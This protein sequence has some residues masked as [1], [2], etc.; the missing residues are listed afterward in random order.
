MDDERDITSL[1]RLEYSYG[2]AG[3]QWTV[4]PAV[5]VPNGGYGY[6]TIRAFPWF[7]Q[8]CT[9]ENNVQRQYLV[10]NALG[11]EVSAK[12]KQSLPFTSD[13]MVP[14]NT[15]I[16]LN[17]NSS[18]GTGTDTGTDPEDVTLRKYWTLVGV[19]MGSPPFAVNNA[20]D[21]EIAPLS[22]V[23]YGQSETAEVSN[24]QETANT[25]M[26]SA[27][28]TVQAGLQHVF[29]VKDQVDASYKHAWESANETSTKSTVSYGFTLGTENA[30]TDPNDADQIG[31]MGWAIFHVPTFVV[32]D[33]ALY[34]YDYDVGTMSGTPTGQD[35]HTTQVNQG[36]LSYRQVAFELAS[37][38]G[39][40]DSFPGLMSG[41]APLTTSTDF[42]GW[43]QGWESNSATSATSHYTT[44]LGDSTAGETKINTITFVNG[45]NGQASFS[46]DIET[47]TTTGQTSDVDVSNQ[48]SLDLGTEVNGFKADLKAGYDGHF[49][50]SVTNTTTLGSDVEA[51]LG[52]PACYEPACIKTLTVQPYLLQATDNNAPWIPAGYN[53]QLPWAMHWK[54]MSYTTIGGVQSGVSPP[55]SQ[56]SGIIVGTSEGP[57]KASRSR[58]SSYSLRGGKM[59]WQEDDG[60]LK[61]IPMKARE[62][63]PAL[64]VSLELNGYT[65]S[66][67]EADGKWSRRGS[68]WTFKTNRRVNKDIVVLKLNFATM[69]WDLDLSKADLSPFLKVSEG[70]IHVELSVNG[71]YELYFDCE[72]QVEGQWD[73]TPLERASSDGLGL[74]LSRYKGFFDPFTGMGI[75]TLEGDLPTGLQHFGDISFLVNG[76]QVDVPLISRENYAKALA[77][78]KKL[79]VR[80]KRGLQ[81]FLDFGKNKWQVYFHGKIH[82]L[83]MPRLA[84]TKIQVKVGGEL[85][86]QGEHNVQDYTSRLEYVNPNPT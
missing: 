11:D 6:G 71:K 29:G 78:G 3:G 1:R 21:F 60:T 22:N 37:P 82:P 80:Q 10:V 33:Y 72:H 36:D 53:S 40:N 5:F 68:I 50:N 67:S 28:L 85:R 20:Q 48:T 57:E 35:I 54:I 66:S 56:A 18:G 45:S 14:Q 26:V 19:V 31:A 39:P 75:A 49:S 64:G 7:I 24:S 47:V 73:H 59:V 8:E 65:W 34:A 16:P 43:K 30:S 41:L 61:P 23:T 74:S 42:T 32:Q 76:R 44:L 4:D 17:C 27:G 15:D 70:R 25:V 46:Q 51:A 81:L 13:A 62:F 38:G 69:S 9:A 83:L 58:G 84:A 12:A 52:I 86:Y 2:T 77:K 63:V 55:P 79:V